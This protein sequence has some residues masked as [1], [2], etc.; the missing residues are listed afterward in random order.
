MQRD[1]DRRVSGVPRV[2][3]ERVVDVCERDSPQAAFRGR[4]VDISGRGMQLYASRPP[5]LETPLV[6]RFREQ[7]QEII[8]EGEVA[9]CNE[10]AEGAEFGVRFTALDS[11]SVQSLKALCQLEA[12]FAAPS[13]PDAEDADRDTDPAPPVAPVVKLH[14]AG[15]GEPMRAQVREQ[16][17]RGVTVASGLDFLRL[18]RS[19][20]VEDMA[21]GGR[22]AAEIAGV[23]VSLD[24]ASRV[25]ELVVSLRYAEAA[26]TPLAGKSRPL[27]MSRTAREE[28]HGAAE[29]P[30]PK[31]IF[32]SARRTGLAEPRG[33][34]ARVAAASRDESHTPQPV[35]LR[36]SDA[37]RPAPHE[38]RETPEPAAIH[39]GAR[40]S[41]ATGL[42]ASRPG[43]EP[44]AIEREPSEDDDALYAGAEGRDAG[45]PGD[46]EH[47]GDDGDPGDEGASD[48]QRLRERLDGVITGV[49]AAARLA[50]EQAVRVGGAASRGARW[51]AEHAKTAAHSRTSRAA[52]LRRTTSAAPRALMRSNPA[53]RQAPGRTPSS[54]VQRAAPRRSAL[55]VALAGGLLTSV[56]L[57]LG[58]LLGSPAEPSAA[59]APASVAAPAAAAPVSGAAPAA[60]SET[61][62]A[63]GEPAPSPS[64][65]PGPAEEGD[66]EDGVEAVAQVPLFGPTG[67][68]A[69]ATSDVS[70]VQPRAL[71]RAK[72][73]DETFGDS[74]PRAP[75]KTASPNEFG[76]GRM[77][78]PIV[79][80]LRLDQPGQGLRGERTPTGFD[81]VIPGRKAMESGTAISR[82]DD[83]ISRVVTRNGPEG[84]R[85][86]FR[87]RGTIPAYKVRLR[88]DFI[89]FFISS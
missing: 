38:D 9:W 77:H 88:K 36:R 48:A 62:P 71:A 61:P 46:D 18:G 55:R 22:R 29:E 31:I 45:D 14:I 5:E 16:A 27:V 78:L 12:A 83:R 8:A 52:P 34:G 64:P 80:R 85:I 4:S 87:F 3:V 15:L 47:P 54:A 49:S 2:P 42:R 84:A 11:R 33:S 23:D 57:G 39:A 10:G 82:R 20:D 56:A 69:K 1:S 19:V 60:A 26:Q 66:P 89:E 40:E 51:L 76:N 25:P 32:D 53:L 43:A 44:R 59:V 50:S 81:V 86:S 21:Q 73:N 30:R 75:A 72:V 58:L 6:L 74:A 70:D 37:R 28:P 63:N 17:G 13:E 24:E 7:G 65:A 79:Y 67:L 41:G 35:E 68:G